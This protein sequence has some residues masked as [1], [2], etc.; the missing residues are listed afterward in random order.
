[1]NDGWVG[2]MTQHLDR[3]TQNASEEGPPGV[4]V[5]AYGAH[6]KDMILEVVRLGYVNHLI[7]DRS[8]ADE[9]KEDC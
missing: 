1:M 3:I 8:L 6:K 7:V 5:V 2:F 4:I 9:L